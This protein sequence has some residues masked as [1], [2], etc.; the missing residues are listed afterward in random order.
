MLI[1]NEFKVVF[2]STCLLLVFGDPVGEIVNDGFV[3][4]MC[5]VFSEMHEKL[6]GC[7]VVF[8]QVRVVNGSSRMII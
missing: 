4:E 7:F 3:L 6:K 1:I 8:P 2:Y 5:G